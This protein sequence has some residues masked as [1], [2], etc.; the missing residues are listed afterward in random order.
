[1]CNLCKIA[2][3]V[4][5]SHLTNRCPHFKTVEERLEVVNKHKKCH[6]CLQ[7]DAAVGSTLCNGDH[8]PHLLED[9]CKECIIRGLAEMADSH[10]IFLC[11]NKWS[12]DHPLLSPEEREKALMDLSP[13]YVKKKEKQQQEEAQRA[14]LRKKMDEEVEQRRQLQAAMAINPGQPLPK[15]P[16]MDWTMQ[17]QPLLYQQAAQPPPTHKLP[18]QS[19]KT[20]G[21]VMPLVEPARV[22]RENVAQMVSGIKAQDRSG[23]LQ[24][25][26][27]G[28]SHSQ[29]IKTPSL[30]S[31]T[32]SVTSLE[33]PERKRKRR[34][35]FKNQYFQVFATPSPMPPVG[36]GKAWSIATAVESQKVVPMDQSL[37]AAQ[38]EWRAADQSQENR[39]RKPRDAAYIRDNANLVADLVRAESILLQK[40]TELERSKMANA[41]LQKELDESM[42][43]EIAMSRRLTKMENEFEE[44]L[45]AEIAKLQGTITKLTNELASVAAV[46]DNYVITVQTLQDQRD[47][48][49]DEAESWKKQYLA[50][51]GQFKEAKET[52]AETIGKLLQEKAEALLKVKALE[53]D[54]AQ[55]ENQGPSKKKKQAEAKKTPE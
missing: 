5:K 55:K 25:N 53:N 13:A 41:K 15:V 21:H 38:R 10:C 27:K 36:L 3:Y 6:G 34:R 14:E 51:L 4:V 49:L 31:L 48:A 12:K 11:P 19:K 50:V 54:L 22:V 17:P 16:P 29:V 23:P 42:A 33:E 44:K 30:T 39:K 28:P 24:T 32:S 1:M 47:D 8:C 20:A 2:G 40:E 45:Q 26:A 18:P 35:N 7:N 46:R 43:Q 9:P 52:S 37:G